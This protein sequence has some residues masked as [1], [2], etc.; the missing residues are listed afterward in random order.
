MSRLLDKGFSHFIITAFPSSIYHTCLIKQS[1]V[2]ARL[3]Q[4]VRSRDVLTAQISRYQFKDPFNY[5]T[6]M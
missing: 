6:P 4:L 3:M 5:A 2:M 1:G